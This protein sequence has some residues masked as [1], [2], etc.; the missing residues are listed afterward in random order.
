M[1]ID[2]RIKKAELAREQLKEQTRLAH[3]A[4]QELKGQQR[5][6]RQMQADV[7]KLLDTEIEN[8]LSQKV[9]EGLDDFGKTVEQAMADSVAKVISEFDGLKDI[10]LGQTERER[11]RGEPSIPELIERHADG[12][13]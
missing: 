2:E 12:N 10:L 11:R 1:E 4:I 7:E 13:G 3:E 8:V 5:K 6:L 9:K